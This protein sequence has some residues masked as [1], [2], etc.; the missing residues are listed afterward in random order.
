ML[1]FDQ[2]LTPE[3]YE[4]LAGRWKTKESSNLRGFWDNSAQVSYSDPYVTRYRIGRDVFCRDERWLERVDVSD[5]VLEESDC[6]I[7]VA[8]H[9]IVD[10]AQ[11]VQKAPVIVDT[12]DAT[13]G[14][15][16]PARVVRVGAPL[17]Q[18]GS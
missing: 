17:P 11:V 5:K 16:G 7:I 14:L 1:I 6:V 12:R 9:G 3:H 13:R 8:D 10:Y 2:T 18:S 15:R 4:E